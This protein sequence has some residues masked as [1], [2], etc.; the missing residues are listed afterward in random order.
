M[1]LFDFFR[2]KRKIKAGR[3]RRNRKSTSKT[4][5]AIEKIKADMD[6]LQTQL[7]T[8]N[9]V[10]NKHNNELS[11]HAKLISEH[12]KGLEKLEQIVRKTPINPPA[13]EKTQR[14]RPVVMTK[15]PTTTKPTTEDLSQKFDINRF[16]EQEKRILAVFFQNQGMALSYVDIAMSL[17]KSP[18]TIK[19]QMNRIRLKAELFNRTV[20]NDSRNRFKLKDG[21]RIEKYLNVG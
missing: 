18:H 19:N 5:Q 10:L 6:N 11:E 12:S 13:E 8:I 16:S 14:S 9:I 15:L 3:K 21:L 20:D 4:K 17:D 7:G 1:R 2:K